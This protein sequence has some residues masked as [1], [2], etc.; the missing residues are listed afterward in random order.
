MNERNIFLETFFNNYQQQPQ[1]QGSTL[2]QLKDLQHIANRCGLYD[3]ADYIK[4]G[5]ARIERDDD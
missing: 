4:N 2:A 3:A 1:H 5:I